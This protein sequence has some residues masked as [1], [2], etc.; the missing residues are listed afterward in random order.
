MIDPT[1]ILA[2]CGL[3]HAHQVTPVTGGND[4]LLWKVNTARGTFALRLLRAEQRG[5]W[6]QELRAM[7]VAAAA[8]IP[9]PTVD[10][11]LLWQER[12]VILMSWC[13]GEPV[14]FWLARQPWRVWRLGQAMGRMQA[15]IH[16][17]ALPPD[18]PPPADPWVNF[19]DPHDR[20]IKERL[21]ALPPRQPTLLH[22]DFHPLNLLSDGKQITAVLDWTNAQAGDLRA[23]LA[24]T[25]TIL[26]VD[27]WQGRMGAG[28][29]LFRR[30]FTLAWQTGYRQSNGP[31]GDLALFYAWAGAVMVHD[32]TPRARKPDHWLTPGHIAAIQRW[33]DEQKQ[34]A[35]IK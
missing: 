34:H 19:A 32:L 15:Q 3:E 4:T 29:Q 5:S 1:P 30:C 10:Q 2:A 27:P 17:I 16:R 7:R 20:A 23:D 9:V 31:T 24:R 28:W 18:W 25:Y 21:L 33:T 14:A 22:L 35:G 8:G 11:T 26:R 13:A 6:Q 12:P